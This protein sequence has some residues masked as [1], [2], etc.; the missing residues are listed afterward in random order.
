MVSQ[1]PGRLCEVSM[2]LVHE[3]GV[4]NNRQDGRRPWWLALAR[5]ALALPEKYFPAPVR[6]VLDPPMPA[7]PAG[8][9]GRACL[10]G[11]QEGYRVNGF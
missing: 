4:G 5:L 10:V 2:A 7:D 11:L 3:R 9:L 8:Q 6:A 1:V